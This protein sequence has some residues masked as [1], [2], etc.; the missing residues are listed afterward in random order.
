[1]L[2]T[3]GRSLFGDNKAKARD[4]GASNNVTTP[5]EPT[6]PATTF[7]YA[8]GNVDV[9]RHPGPAYHAPLFQFQEF[10]PNV[11]EGWGGVGVQRFM[12]PFS[13]LTQITQLTPV[14]TG[15]SGYIQGQFYTAPLIDTS[16]I[17][18]VG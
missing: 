14:T 1:M 17:G 6:A 18:T 8:F 7:S 3:L 11:W 15:G 5:Q 10:I 4:T 13:P 12:R 16:G 2:A 9:Q